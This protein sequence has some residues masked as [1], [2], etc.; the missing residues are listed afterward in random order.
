MQI[1]EH[2]QVYVSRMLH[3]SAAIIGLYEHGP[4]WT[5]FWLVPSNVSAV[6]VVVVVV[7]VG[8]YLMNS[9]LRLYGIPKFDSGLATKLISKSRSRRL[10]LF[11]ASNL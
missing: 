7:V 11:P 3:S 2:M 8:L 9:R 4:V 10:P 6:V 1:Y 5:V